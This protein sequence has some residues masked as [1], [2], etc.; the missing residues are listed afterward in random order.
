MGRLKAW[1][2]ACRGFVSIGVVFLVAI[3]TV[4]AF[5]SA[6]SGYNQSYSRSP[7]TAPNSHIDLILLS[8]SDQGNGQLKIQFQTSGTLI[9][10]DS[11]YDYY[12]YFGGISS[13]SST[14]EVSFSNN[15]TVGTVVSSSGFGT[16]PYTLSNGGTEL[17]FFVNTTD[18]PPAS[19]FSINAIATSSAAPYGSSSIGSAFNTVQT[20]ANTIFWVYVG[21][22]IVVLVI[23]VVIVV[24]L[25]T[26]RHKTPPA[27]PP[28]TFVAPTPMPGP[29]PP[30][31]QSP[32][33]P[34]PPPPQP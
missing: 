32:P 27:P 20:I 26:K 16:V 31:S 9:L 23:V 29:Y 13:S 4:S 33:P 6:A 1:G 11:N 2:P 25:I 3:V 22:G 19:S 12:V 10:T 18:V 14:S 30:S 21:I 28:A 17:T 8:S 24:V 5:A 34:P 15:T 7:G